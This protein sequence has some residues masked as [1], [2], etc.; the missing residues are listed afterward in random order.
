MAIFLDSQLFL[1]FVVTTACKLS[2]FSHELVLF[3]VVSWPCTP[4]STF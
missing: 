4:F 2:D 1:F 3:V